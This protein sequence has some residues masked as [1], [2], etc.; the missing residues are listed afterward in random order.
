M[1]TLL[2]KLSIRA[3]LWIGFGLIL[4]I[5]SVSSAITL[6]NLGGVGRQVHEVVHE[7]QPTVMLTKDLATS[8]QRASS[9]M[10]FFL[11]TKE[12]NY[13]QEH[14]AQLAQAKQIIQDLE[15]M[16]IVQ[17]DTASIELV[18]QLSNDIKQFESISQALIEKATSYESNFPGIAF[19]NENINPISRV[20][21][22]LTSQMIMSEMEE[23]ADDE[24]KQLLADIAELRYAWSNI[25]N[26][27]RGYLAFRSDANIR[28]LTLYI[29]RTDQLLARLNEQSDLLTLDQADSLEQFAQGLVAFKQHYA[30]LLQIHGSEQWRMD[31]WL[32]RSKLG[33]LYKKIDGN[34]T[35]LVNQQQNAIQVTSNQLIEDSDFTLNLVKGLLAFGLIAGLLISWL[36]ARAICRPILEASNTM[37]D[38]ASGDGDLMRSLE[39]KSDDELGQLADAFN[40]FVAKIR[41]LIQRTAHSTESVI[42]AVAQT[43]DNTGEIIKRILKQEVE[44]DQVATA[45]QQMTSSITEVAKNA[46]V[47]EASAQAASQEAVSGRNMVQQSAD[48]ILDLSK[49]VELAEQTIQGV[50]QESAR[51]GSVLDVIKSIAEQ[52]NLLALN[53]AIEAARAGEQG[54]G[55]AVV[56]DEVRSLATRTQESTGEIEAMVRSLQNGTQRA[57][58]VMASG[59]QK[60]DLNVSQA[61]QTLN[62]LSEISNAVETINQ[63]NSQIATAAEQQ[64]AV[65]EEIN[66]NI[67]NINDNSKQTAKHAKETAET[68]SALGNFA[69]NLQDVIQQ[70]KFSGDSGLDFSAAKSAH[71]AWKARLR[72]FLDGGL[73]LHQNEAVSHQDCVLGKWYYAEGLSRYGHLSEMREIEK[74][75]QQLHQLIKEI[76]KLKEAGMQSESEARYAEIEPLSKEIIQQL[77]RVEEKILAPT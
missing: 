34:L 47:A 2:K 69:A 20:H 62:S 50:E 36:I 77:N 31:A 28:D 45:M 59:R 75:H 33:P 49:E 64:R 35:S 23:S 41:D 4:S 15:Q 39:R 65:A 51:I 43:S 3:K 17:Q 14:A 37:Q 74:P 73:S 18:K 19:A 30:K 27:I 46:A 56:A 53:A 6:F 38:I 71:L 7:R 42:A 13:H 26:G 24:R 25:M 57:V 40:V 54:R 21:L 32:V 9:A 44:T 68:V 11:L 63:M 67:F 72:E 55:F 70:F 10:G 16:P 66:R 60:V 1:L 61:R 8:L 58:T 48:A 12:E 29:E 5:L 76:I 52:T 22:Q